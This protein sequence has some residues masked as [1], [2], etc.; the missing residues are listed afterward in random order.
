MT[1]EALRPAEYKAQ[2]RRT[3]YMTFRLIDKK[4]KTT[5]WCVENNKSGGTLGFIEW[6]GPWRQYVF[7]PLEECVFNNDC[8]SEIAT[9]L[10]DLNARQRR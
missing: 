4:P 10:T 5:E 2:D 8:L 9:F 6:Y 7:T 3:K 1:M